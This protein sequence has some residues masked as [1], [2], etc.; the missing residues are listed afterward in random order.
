MHTGED[1]NG[2]L[3]CAISSTLYLNRSTAQS[4]SNAACLYRL[5]SKITTTLSREAFSGFW[6]L[7]GK[8][9]LSCIVIQ[10]NA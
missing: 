5:M 3:E 2:G 10:L 1:G 7:R 6:R 9:L 4:L 8:F